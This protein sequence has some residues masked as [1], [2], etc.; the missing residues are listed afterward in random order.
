VKA[1]C[2]PS[3]SGVLFEGWYSDMF[4]NTRRFAAVR[5]VTGYRIVESAAEPGDRLVS[6][7]CDA[8]ANSC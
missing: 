7:F 8:G 5:G 1:R 4:G 6:R 3:S 2:D